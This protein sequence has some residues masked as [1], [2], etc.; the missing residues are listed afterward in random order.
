MVIIKNRKFGHCQRPRL[1]F[2][3]LEMKLN[4]SKN[5]Q[6]KALFLKVKLT[7]IIPQNKNSLKAADYQKTRP[8]LWVKTKFFGISTNSV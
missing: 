8:I 2:L 7:F 3:Q 6:N 1:Y 5:F 4:S